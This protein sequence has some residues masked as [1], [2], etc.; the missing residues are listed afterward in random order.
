[1]GIN[2]T[3]V[4]RGFCSTGPR[5]VKRISRTILPYL[6]PDPLAT[7]RDHK[8]LWVASRA[9]R[10]ALDLPADSRF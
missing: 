7:A 8:M 6:V 2:H 4:I 3:G 5:P 10:R 9:Q 1:L